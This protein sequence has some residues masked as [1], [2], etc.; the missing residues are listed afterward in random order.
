MTAV[1]S[2]FS[3]VF[4]REIPSVLASGKLNAFGQVEILLKSYSRIMKLL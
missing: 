1:V 2:S 3:E 4:Q